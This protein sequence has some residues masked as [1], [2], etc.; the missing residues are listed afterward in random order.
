M[1]AGTELQTKLNV[2]AFEYAAVCE[3][4]GTDKLDAVRLRAKAVKCQAKMR[5][6]QVKPDQTTKVLR[7]YY[8]KALKGGT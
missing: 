5:K 3:L 6:L 4:H 7:E 2:F 8:G 1:T